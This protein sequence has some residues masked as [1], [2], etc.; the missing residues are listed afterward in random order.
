MK[1]SAKFDDK[2]IEG[3]DIQG[4]KEIEE[5]KEYDGH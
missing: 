2:Y 1:Y 5:I 3:K 4:I